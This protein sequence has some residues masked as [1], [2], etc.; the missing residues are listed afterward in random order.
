MEF[1]G[2]GLFSLTLLGGAW[3][4]THLMSRRNE[5]NLH[6]RESRTWTE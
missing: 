3:Y 4:L 5:G 2:F 1:L 6:G